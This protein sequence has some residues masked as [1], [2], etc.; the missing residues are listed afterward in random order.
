[1]SRKD[2]IIRILKKHQTPNYELEVN[3]VY[4]ENYKTIATEIEKLFEVEG[5]TRVD[6]VLQRYTPMHGWDD[7]STGWEKEAALSKTKKDEIRAV[8]R[9]TKDEV[10][11]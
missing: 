3:A 9:T 6:Y 8:K 2:E 5:E 1:M 11:E 7:S 4:S 10:I